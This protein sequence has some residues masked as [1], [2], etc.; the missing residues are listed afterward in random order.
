MY[1]LTTPQGTAAAE[2]ALCEK[3]VKVQE[4][5]DRAR[6]A[7]DRADFPEP[8]RVDFQDCTGNDALEC[9]VCGAR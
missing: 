2:T 3:H 9:V 8:D 1:A 7:A 6:F 5:R 4:D